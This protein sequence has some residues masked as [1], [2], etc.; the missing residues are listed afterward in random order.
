MPSLIQYIQHAHKIYLRAEATGLLYTCACQRALIC[1]C[2]RTGATILI[3]I[4]GSY[5]ARLIYPIGYS[6]RHC[7]QPRRSSGSHR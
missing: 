6:R 7:G 5:N 2:I 4:M 1:A 3:M